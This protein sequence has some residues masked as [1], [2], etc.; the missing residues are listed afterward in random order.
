[1]KDIFGNNAMTM[2]DGVIVLTILLKS[3][4]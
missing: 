1:V 2:V 4:K 3:A